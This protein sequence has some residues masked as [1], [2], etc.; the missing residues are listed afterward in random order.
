M[1]QKNILPLVIKRYNFD[2]AL[3]K[4]LHEMSIGEKSSIL[5]EGPIGRGLELGNN[6]KGTRV[7]LCAGTGILPFLD[8]LNYLLMKTMYNE[9][10]KKFNEQ[11]AESINVFKENYATASDPTFNVQFF[12]AFPN[13]N[14]IPG[15][16]ILNKLALVSQKSENPIFKAKI[17]NSHDINIE[18]VYGYFNQQNLSESLKINDV[19]HIYIC[20]TPSF[21]REMY[22]SLKKLNCKIEKV[23]LV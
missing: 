12:G 22:L 23:S 17:R 3:S 11:I 21:N 4:Q 9:L 18:S 5:I 19:E 8:L 2:G 15:G 10:K 20:G 1:N 6:P 14:E 13:P 7:I 16:D